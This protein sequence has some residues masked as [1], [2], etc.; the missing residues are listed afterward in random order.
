MNTVLVTG[1]AGF[2][3]SRLV[4]CLLGRGFHVRVVDNL[5]SGR[6][7]HISHHFGSELFE[8]VEGDLKNPEVAL[9]A[10][11]EVNTVFHLAANPEVRLSVTEPAVHFNENLLATFNLLEAC[12]RKGVLN[13]SFSR[14]RARFTV[15]PACSRPLKP[16]R[17]SL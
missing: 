6:L 1:G 14:A 4:D 9:K 12:R 5:S 13:S 16:M 7:E 8:F 17:S 10:V 11:E 15:T 3:G 2:I